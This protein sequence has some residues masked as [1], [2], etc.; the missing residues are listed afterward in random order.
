VEVPPSRLAGLIH[1]L[2]SFDWPPGLHEQIQALP[3]KMLESMGD[4]WRKKQE[5]LEELKK[6]ER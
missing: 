3:P 1:S 5:N 4:A 6:E 2:Q